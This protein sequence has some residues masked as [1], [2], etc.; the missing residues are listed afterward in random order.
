M[1]NLIKIIAT[2]TMLGTM[3]ACGAS[4]VLDDL[5]NAIGE[6][7]NSLQN[8]RLQAAAR[9]I[10]TEELAEFRE[11]LDSSLTDQQRED[12]VVAEATRLANLSGTEKAEFDAKVQTR[13]TYLAEVAG[14]TASERAA[15]LDRCQTDDTGDGCAVVLLT[16]CDDTPFNEFCF[17]DPAYD[18]RRVE[19]C[20]VDSVRNNCEDTVFRVCAANPF[21]ALCVND[22]RYNTVRAVR[23]AVNDTEKAS[24][25][26]EATVKRVCD[27]DVEDSL[28]DLIPAYTSQRL[29]LDGTRA[30]YGTRNCPAR[31]GDSRCVRLRIF[32]CTREPLDPFCDEHGQYRDARRTLCLA[33]T[34]DPVACATTVSQVCLNNP[35]DDLCDGLDTYAPA[36]EIACRGESATSK[37]EC[38]T[39]LMRVCGNLEGTSATGDPFGLT[40]RNDAFQPARNAISLACA[41]DPT[42]RL[43][44]SERNQICGNTPFNPVCKRSEYLPLQIR[45]CIG[46]E[47]TGNCID[48]TFFT[49]PVILSCLTNPLDVACTASDSAFKPYEID[50]QD[51]TCLAD[52]TR[53]GCANPTAVVFATL[54]TTIRALRQNPDPSVPFHESTNQYTSGFV[55]FDSTVLNDDTGDLDAAKINALG[56]YLTDDTDTDG[57]AQNRTITIR[58]GGADSTNEDGVAYFY[59]FGSTS[60]DAETSYSYGGI[61]STTNL[62]APLD[63]RPAVAGNNVTAIWDGHFSFR[64]DIINRATEFLVDFTDGTMGFA[65]PVGTDG[66]RPPGTT[67]LGVGADGTHSV[68]WFNLDLFVRLDA[69]FGPNAK[70][71]ISTYDTVTNSVIDTTTDLTL[72]PGQLGGNVFVYYR[73]ATDANP[74]ADPDNFV[75]DNNTIHG[76]IGQEGAVAVFL[77]PG[78][79]GSV[80]LAEGATTRVG[81]FTVSNPDHPNNQ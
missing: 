47:A 5:A 65:K 20:E 67:F 76:L 80:K 62:G 69:A 48:D 78:I 35:L 68:K 52:I 29:T 1:K 55:N 75:R 6:G 24:T 39:T 31:P 2:M 66:I 45:A 8:L 73:P 25:R 15:N 42:G 11:N 81:G 12:M 37:P 18:D 74:D 33:E 60:G 72:A 27:L 4:G 41:G 10:R 53:A 28:C 59:H 64:G 22:E 38:A 13:V 32:I 40:C 50:A 63:V 23:C 16:F 58:R 30:E 61:L 77:A 3:T 14:L 79:G 57:L 51:A 36:Q 9:Q 46:K 44:V 26:C 71:K 70:N 19:I 49:D 43:C 7:L 54:P 56:D 21:I 17:S 34:A